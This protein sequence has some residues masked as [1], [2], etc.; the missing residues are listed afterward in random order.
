MVTVLGRHSLSSTRRQ[1]DVVVHFFGG[2]PDGV[3]LQAALQR[4]VLRIESTLR[5][6]MAAMAASLALTAS[7]SS[8]ITVTS[9]AST[10]FRSGQYAI[11]LPTP[12]L[13]AERARRFSALG[14]QRFAG[15]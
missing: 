1:N 14:K 2:T 4:S 7:L 5:G 11:T 15:S 10:S 6:V 12:S 3:L 8:R 13:R 9:A